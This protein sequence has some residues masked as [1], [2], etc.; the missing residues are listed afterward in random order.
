MDA[1]EDRIYGEDRRGDELPEELRRRE[2]RLAQIEAAMKRLK[3]RQAEED[4]EIDDR[5]D[6][7][8]RP[9]ADDPEPGAHEEPDRRRHPDPCRCRQTGDPLPGP[10]DRARTEETHAGHDGCG[11]PNGIATSFDEGGLSED[12]DGRAGEE[13][14]TGADDRVRPYTGGFVG[15]LAVE[16]DDPGEN[17]SSDAPEEQLE[18]SHDRQRTRRP[19]D[20]PGYP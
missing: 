17:R 3:D 16:S 12:Q 9:D 18:F 6:Q 20:H 4:R 14:R 7:H 2:D 1:E 10:Q 19:F 11:N 8:R 13:G 15:S 5:N